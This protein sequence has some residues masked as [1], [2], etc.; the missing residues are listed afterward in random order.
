VTLALRNVFSLAAGATQTYTTQTLFGN[1]VPPAPGSLETLPLLPDTLDTGG[2]FV[3]NIDADD[4]TEGEIIFIDPVIAT[5]YTYTVTGADFTSVQ[6]PSFAAVADMD[7]YILSVGGDDYALASG[8]LIN[9]ADLG[10]AGITNFTITGIDEALMLDPANTAAFVTG[11]ALGNLSTQTITLTQAAIETDT[12]ANGPAIVPLPASAF[13]LMGGM[14][15]LGAL[16][17]RKRHS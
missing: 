3:F 10:L 8:Q 13:L 7:G 6:A 17:R 4:I 1:S 9:F 2:A 14:F 16:R 11:V 12:D 5:G 15:G